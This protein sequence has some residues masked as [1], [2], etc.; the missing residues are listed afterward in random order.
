MKPPA[1]LDGNPPAPDNFPVQY[2]TC[3]PP[4]PS[5]PSGSHSTAARRVL[6]GLGLQLAD[7]SPHMRHARK[8][9][10]PTPLATPMPDA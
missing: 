4:V 7:A 10:L 5:A 8:H 1:L 2:L 9:V 3:S 6:C